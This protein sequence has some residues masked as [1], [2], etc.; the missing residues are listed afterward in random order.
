M[1]A[2]PVYV[3]WR[4][5]GKVHA[6][7]T[8]HYRGRRFFESLIRVMCGR[9]AKPYYVQYVDRGPAP[10]RQCLRIVKRY[11]EQARG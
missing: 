2:E 10:C 7:D 5:D 4:A 6:L 3:Q 8:D 1:S 9:T 11:E